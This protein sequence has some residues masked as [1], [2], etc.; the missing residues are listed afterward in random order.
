MDAITGKD[1]RKKVKGTIVLMKKNVLDFTDVNA[2]VLDGVLE[3]LGRRVSF[4]LISTSV[5][6]N[7]KYLFIILFQGFLSYII[8]LLNV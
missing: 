1:D 3:F 7:G 5:H 8:H 6:D 4:Q 2:S